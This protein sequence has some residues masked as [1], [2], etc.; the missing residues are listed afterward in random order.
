M[1]IE[2]DVS[3]EAV[4]IEIGERLRRHRLARNVTQQTLADEAGIGI[5]TLKSM[6]GGRPTG[7]VNLIRVLRRLDLLRNLDAV[8]PDAAPLVGVSGPS[9]TTRRRARPVAQD[10]DDAPAEPWRWG[11]ER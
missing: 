6:E 1:R 11:D 5:T 4:L 8:V 9:D 2:N 3:D 10:E 7:V